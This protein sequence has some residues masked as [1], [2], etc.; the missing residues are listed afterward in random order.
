MPLL[1]ET[2]G[3]VAILTLSRPDA[4]NAWDEDYNEGLE[5]TLSEIEKDHAIR[6]VVLT[7]DERGAAFS[8]GANLSDKTTHTVDSAGAFITG[9][10]E[11]RK[12]VANLLTDFPKPVIAAVNGYAI[13]IGCI[14]T[15]CCDLIVAS[16]RA[17]WRLPQVRLGIMP[18]YGGAVRLARWVGKG[19]AMRAALG[20]PITA[21]EAYRTGLAQWLVPHDQLMAQA[22]SVAEDIAALPPL[23]SRLVKESLNKGLDIPNIKDASEADVYRFMVLSQ[24]EDSKEAHLAWREKRKPAV[25]GR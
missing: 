23:S 4:R 6:C 13:G 22:M 21:A 18:A 17:E 9:I 16:E 3:N 15:Y 1:Y 5:K 19:N 2:R 20:Y 11:W 25:S 10:P 8:A 7:G 24:T 14:A 12:F